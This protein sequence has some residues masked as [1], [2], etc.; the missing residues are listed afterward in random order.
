MTKADLVKAHKEGKVERFCF[1]DFEGNKVWSK[2][3]QSKF[4]AD[5]NPETYRIVK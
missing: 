1:V 4:E 2:V 3:L 5:V